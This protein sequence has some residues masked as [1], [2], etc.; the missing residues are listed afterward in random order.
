MCAESGAITVDFVVITAI[1]VGFGIGV[2]IIVT[3]GIMSVA[4]DQIDP[5][6]KSYDGL[7]DR[8]FGPDD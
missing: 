3:P 4:T 7:A 6:I 1:I 8:L 2:M 5:V